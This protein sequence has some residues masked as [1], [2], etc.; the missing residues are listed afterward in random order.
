M[1]SKLAAGELWKECIDP[2]KKDVWRVLPIF[3]FFQRIGMIS[4][5]AKI[6]RTFIKALFRCIK[7][8]PNLHTFLVELCEDEDSRLRAVGESGSLQPPPDRT[9]ASST[10]AASSKQN[11]LSLTRGRRNRYKIARL[12]SHKAPPRLDASKKQRRL[13]RLWRLQR[14]RLVRPARGKGGK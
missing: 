10:S 12:L 13:E 9:T 14:S 4:S 8:T 5:P 7:D 3:E 1:K 6:P 2:Y 11:A